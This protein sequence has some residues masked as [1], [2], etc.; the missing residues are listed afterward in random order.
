MKSSVV[1]GTEIKTCVD[2]FKFSKISL[3]KLLS[4]KEKIFFSF[5][6]DLDVPATSKSIFS[7]NNNSTKYLAVKPKPKQ[8]NFILLD[9]L[10]FRLL[11]RNWVL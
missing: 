3:S 8:N 7:L 4:S 9:S 2:V 5:F 1:G 6:S 11:Q 10:L